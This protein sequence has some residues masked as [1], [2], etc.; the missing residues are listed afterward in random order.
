MVMCDFPIILT[1]DFEGVS[2]KYVT[3]RLVKKIVQG[4]SQQYG[5]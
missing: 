2:Q 5:F 4:K 3:D 1:Q